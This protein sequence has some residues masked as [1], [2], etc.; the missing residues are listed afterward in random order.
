MRGVRKITPISKLL[1]YYI[2]V[3]LRGVRKITPVILR[4]VRKITPIIYR[5]DFVSGYAKLLLYIMGEHQCVGVHYINA[6]TPILYRGN[7]AYPYYI[8]DFAYP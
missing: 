3:I 8:G 1:L 5:S 7:F 4:G 2:G 6:A